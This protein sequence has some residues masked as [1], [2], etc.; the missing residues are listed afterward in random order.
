M[1]YLEAS[2]F[3]SAVMVRIAS[4]WRPTHFICRM[5]IASSLWKILHYKLGSESTVM[6]SRTT[7]CRAV[8]IGGCLMKFF[9]GRRPQMDY[10]FDL[11]P[12]KE[13]QRW[14]IT[15]GKPFLFGGRLM[16]VPLHIGRLGHI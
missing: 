9:P 15:C 12:S 11:Q 10:A 14:Y 6:Q 16:L 8:D 4:A 5:G 3:G 13:Y 1:P 2:G 7:K